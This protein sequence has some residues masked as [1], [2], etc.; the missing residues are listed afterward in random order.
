MADNFINNFAASLLAPLQRTSRHVSVPAVPIFNAC[1]PHIPS[2]SHAIPYL[3]PSHSHLISP[4]RLLLRPFIIVIV[5]VQP[6]LF[7]LPSESPLP[8]SSLIFLHI[9]R[10]SSPSLLPSHFLLSAP[11]FPN[12]LTLITPSQITSSSFILYILHLFLHF[13]LHNSPSPSSPHPPPLF[14][15]FF[16]LLFSLLFHL[17]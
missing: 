4:S 9:S 17:S 1:S 7:P 12:P 6:V 13:H 2:I 8:Y 10:H 16:Y 5:V 14:L 15:L 11:D 3:S